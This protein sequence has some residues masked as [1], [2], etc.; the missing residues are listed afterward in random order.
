MRLR[1]TI[2]GIVRK[3][4]RRGTSRCSSPLFRFHLGVIHIHDCGR[5]SRLIIDWNTKRK[6]IVSKT[7]INR[8]RDNYVQFKTHTI[9]FTSTTSECDFSSIPRFTF[10]TNI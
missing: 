5:L 10:Q 4:D 9:R 2:I 1:L 3:N 7:A 6:V 8:I